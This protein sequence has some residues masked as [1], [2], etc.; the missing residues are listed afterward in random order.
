MNTN[1]SSSVFFDEIGASRTQVEIAHEQEIEI[2]KSDVFHISWMS[3]ELI[4]FERFEGF[5]TVIGIE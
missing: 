2:M 5:P 4:R 1:A 3:M